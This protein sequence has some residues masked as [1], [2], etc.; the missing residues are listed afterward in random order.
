MP[1]T[2]KDVTAKIQD[3]KNNSVYVECKLLGDGSEKNPYIPEIFKE[4]GYYHLDC[5]D[6]D[7]LNKK[8]KVYVNKKLTKPQI[9]TKIRNDIKYVTINET[10]Q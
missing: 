10:G 8:V 4:G 1:G 3:T 5:S 9:L 2:N 6:I 7:Y